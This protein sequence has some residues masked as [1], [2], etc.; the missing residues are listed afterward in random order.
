MA[1]TRRQRGYRSLDAAA[2]LVL[3]IALL[4]SDLIHHFAIL[5]P[6]TGTPEFHLKYP[7]N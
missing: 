5:W 1:R 7:A 3:G 6:L 4:A 2:A